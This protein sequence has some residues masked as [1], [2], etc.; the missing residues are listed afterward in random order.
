MKS[1]YLGNAGL[2]VSELGFG[3]MGLNS[4]YG[5][6][7]DR[8][9]MIKLV[10]DAVDMGVSFFDTA[11]VY[12]PHRNEELVGEALEPIRDQVVIATKFGYDLDPNGGAAPIGLNSRP[13][14]IRETLDGSLRRLR[15]D[16]VDL[17]YQHRVD[18]D[19]PIEEVAGAVSELISA[20]KVRHFG[21]SEVSSD[22]V[23]RAHAACPV[24]AVQSEYSLW[25]REPESGLLRT[26]EELGI[27]FVAYSPLGR[28]FLA[29]GINTR[30]AFAA[31][32]F[33]AVLPRF[34]KKAIEKNASL[35]DILSEIAARKGI[36]PAQ[37]SIAWLLAQR[38]WIVPIP[39]TTKS[40][41]L[42]ENID[43]AQIDLS[44]E[45]LQTV[46]MAVAEVSIH[47]ERYGASE[48][49]NLNR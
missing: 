43:A 37:L 42:R 33:R 28:G 12:G 41:R 39:G 32:D 17:Y 35:I 9:G 18:P 21:L 38:P 48:M 34:Q 45:D 14:H 1:R 10:R 49:Q 36:T 23:R 11:Q 25:A 5:E 29:G 16:H 3:C 40:E 22:T 44:T 4:V 13:Q 2:V 30:S 8:N 15:T 24:T 47:G 27:G 20:G 19:V 6:T 46:S 31:D 26:L 7:T